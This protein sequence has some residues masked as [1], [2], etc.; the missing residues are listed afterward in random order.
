MSKR[1]LS[2]FIR[3]LPKEELEEQIMDLYSRFKEVK[4]YY[5]FVFNPKEDKLFE[6]ARTKIALEYFPQGRRRRAKLRRTVATR[7]FKHFIKLQ[8]DPM[9]IADL[10]L[11][12]I[13]TA[14][15]YCVE[16]TVYQETF[17]RAM[18]KSFEE[19]CK[20]SEDHGIYSDYE[21]RFKRIIEEAYELE[22]YNANGFERV[23]DK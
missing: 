7:F 18:L 4:T 11:F 19:A 3:E 20:F 14:Q 21:V 12:H 1:A 22:W 5:D 16:K 10:M 9:K 6:E 2:K 15:A 23:L 13:E 17:Y 8:A